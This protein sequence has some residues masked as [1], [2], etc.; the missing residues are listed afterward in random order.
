MVHMMP[1]QRAMDGRRRTVRKKLML[2]PALA[3]L[4]QL[5]SV[6]QVCPVALLPTNVRTTTGRESEYAGKRYGTR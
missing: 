5:G 4:E 2:P 6:E 1:R 3:R